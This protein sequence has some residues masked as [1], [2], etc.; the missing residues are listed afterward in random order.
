MPKILVELFYANWCG[1]C[2]NV[3]PLWGVNK[4]SD[5][6]SDENS[7]IGGT[8]LLY[9]DNELLKIATF[10]AHEVNENS[11][12]FKENGVEGFPTIKIQI[13]G[14]KNGE[15]YDYNGDRDYDSIKKHISV[16]HNKKIQKGGGIDYKYKYEKYKSKYDALK[17]S[18]QK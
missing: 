9:N 18:M 14:D 10:E 1:H 3:A 6:S 8:P 13:D 17:K 11:K 16:I 15:K 12:Y 2:K 5:D 4:K 7:Q